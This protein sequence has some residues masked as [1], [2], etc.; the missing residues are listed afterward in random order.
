MNTAFT[1][2]TKIFQTFSENSLSKEIDSENLKHFFVEAAQKVKN[3]EVNY[4]Q[5]LIKRA[6]T[7]TEQILKSKNKKVAIQNLTGFMQQFFYF[8]EARYLL[9]ELYF[10]EE[11]FQN[12][13]R[14]WYLSENPNIEQQNCIKI[15]E[16]SMGGNLEKIATS[17]CFG[18]NQN[19]IENFHKL[20]DFEM[21]KIYNL[22]IALPKSYKLERLIHIIEKNTFKSSS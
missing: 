16:N 7:K 8:K 15:F 18:F 17:I 21:L 14:F 4:N 13:G 20:Q 12:A 3:D 2:F 9:A 1:N 11:E 10:T 22:I 6:F 5:F 19:F